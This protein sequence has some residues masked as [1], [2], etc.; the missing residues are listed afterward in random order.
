MW[1]YTRH[2][3]LIVVMINIITEPQK[4][5]PIRWEP[6]NGYFVSETLS[7]PI[8]LTFFVLLEIL[9]VFWLMSS[10]SIEFTHRNILKLIYRQLF[11]GRPL[12]MI[13]PVETMKMTKSDP[14]TL[15]CEKQTTLNILEE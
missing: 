7:R 13:D 2:Y 15:F 8:F 14:S 12:A 6:A 4:Y 10:P 5:L 9:Q 11:K 3:L 1:I